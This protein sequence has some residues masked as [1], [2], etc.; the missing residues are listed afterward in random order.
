MEQ[1][2]FREHHIVLRRIENARKLGAVTD[3]VVM[4]QFHTLRN[5]FRPRAKEHDSGIVQLHILLE[6]EELDQRNR[7]HNAH[8]HMEKQFPLRDALHHVFGINQVALFGQDGIIRPLLFQALQEYTAGD[9]RFDIGAFHALH[10]NIRSRR[11][12]QVHVHLT[13]DPARKVRNDATARRRKHNAHML[14]TA[15]QLLEYTAKGKGCTKELVSRKVCAIRA[16]NR[17]TGSHHFFT[18]DE[19]RFRNR[20]VRAKR[21]T[22]GIDRDFT[23]NVSN[24]IRIGFF[25]NRCAERNRDNSGKLCRKGLRIRCRRIGKTATPKSLNV[26]RDDYCIRIFN[27]LGIIETER[28]DERSFCHFAFREE[29]NGIAILQSFMDLLQGFRFIVFMN[30]DNA[31]PL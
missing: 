1:R 7:K 27:R 11:V 16:V 21:R 20:L 22:P 18:G 25:R 31:H 13:A 26:E 14:L 19:P 15:K 5:T 29:H 10:H 2:K 17:R 28:S 8:D 24:L 23:H 12:I 4:R 30:T 9:D 3:H 6:V